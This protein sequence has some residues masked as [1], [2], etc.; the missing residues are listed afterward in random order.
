[1]AYGLAKHRARKRKFGEK[2]ALVEA[3]IRR[4]IAHPTAA[5]TDDDARPA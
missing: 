5:L 1:M 3:Q 2:F 4:T